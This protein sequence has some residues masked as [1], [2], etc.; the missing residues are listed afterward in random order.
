MAVEGLVDEAF[1]L[2]CLFIEMN[3]LTDNGV[4]SEGSNEDYSFVFDE[5]TYFPS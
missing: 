4:N 1:G 2:D 3:T 5:K